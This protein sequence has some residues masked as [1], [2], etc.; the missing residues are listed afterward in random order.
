MGP[1]EGSFNPPQ[2]KH[3]FF[4]LGKLIQPGLLHRFPGGL[5]RLRRGLHRLLNQP[6]QR[7]TRLKRSSFEIWLAA[8]QIGVK[9]CKDQKK[10]LPFGGKKIKQ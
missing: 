5:H 1:W 4:P 3:V 2:K 6:M 8:F 9:G 10:Q 7:F